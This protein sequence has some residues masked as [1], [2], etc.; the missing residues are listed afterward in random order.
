MPAGFVTLNIKDGDGTTRTARFWSSDGAATG[1]LIP[2]HVLVDGA[3]AEVLGRV[4]ASPAQYTVLDRLRKAARMFAVQGTQLVRPANTTAYAVGDSISNNATAGLVTPLSAAVSAAIDEPVSLERI[5]IDTNDTGLQGKAI[6]VHIFNSDP[7]A[8][9]GVGA[10]DNGAWSNKRAGYL[11]RFEGY[12][13]TF[14]DGAVATL[15]PSEGNRLVCLP[16]PGTQLLYF[17]FQVL[18]TYTPSAGGTTLT[19]T[20]R[21]TQ[22]VN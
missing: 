18:D 8:N 19:A 10:G 4:A 22:G 3:E 12:F 16:A 17:Q 9:A 1:L 5:T 20:L 6:A 21:G 2:E 7:T 15:F 11:G 13:R 14:S